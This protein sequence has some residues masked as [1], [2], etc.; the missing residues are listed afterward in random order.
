MKKSKPSLFDIIA[1][2]WIAFLLIFTILF[3]FIGF[4]GDYK[5]YQA[6]VKQ[7]SLE[8][9]ENVKDRLKKEVE[10]YIK[11]IETQTKNLQEAKY[12]MLQN[13][14]HKAHLVAENL[15]ENYKD[16]QSQAQI[17]DMIITALRK[18]RF[19]NDGYY[20]IT[21]IN[22]KEILFDEKPELEGKDMLLVYNSDGVFVVKEMI[23]IA[24]KQKE[25][26]YNY[27]WTKPKVQEERIKTSYI[28]LFEPYGWIIGT[29][30]Y[31]ED[32]TKY[33]Q[34]SIL[35]NTEAMKFDLTLDNYIFIG[36]WDGLSMSHPARGKNMYNVQ[37]KNGKYLV[38]ELIQKAR[39]GG[40]FVEYV[41]PSLSNERNSQKI[42]YVQGIAKW[43]W[44]VGAGAYVDDIND[45]IEL[46]KGQL[47]KKF[48]SAFLRGVLLSLTLLILFSLFSRRLNRKVKEDFLI[49]VNFFNK[50]ILN[51][52][53]IDIDKIRFSEFEELGIYANAMLDAKINLE[54]NL[55]K[56]EMIVSSSKD[57]LSL[58]DKDY[59]YVAINETYL[60]YL[61][62][63]KEEIIGKSS[64]EIFGEEDFEKNV[65]PYQERALKGESLTLQRWIKFPIGRRFIDI[66]FFPYKEEG[67]EKIEYFVVSARDWTQKK[68]REDEI[69]LWKRVFENTMEA[70]MIC[71]THMKII[72]VN[73]A[74]VE[75]TG[76]SQEEVIKN[77]W[78]RR[79]T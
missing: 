19:P 4:V 13:R 79:Y 7:L 69:V 59:K 58:M 53:K 52:K 43:Q 44:Y 14:V 11:I 76:Y 55:R 67:K 49:F 45:Q 30:I 6:D 51:N 74:F 77:H 54:D 31:L 36:Q 16:K 8:H 17:K 10:H 37:D 33:I 29:G 21:D 28:K 9:K 62:K 65:K 40:G 20:F 75:I 35:D 47:Y 68:K 1:R 27:K 57:F 34:E 60:R 48:F 41:M 61:Q 71:D 42:S 63:S 66:Q 25:G 22:G 23:E 70:V 46:L 2:Y 50:L 56:Y 39:D 78:F 18:V 5:D 3:L 73:N 24:K 64:V 26:F 38:Q 15:Y 32:L 72:T 12:K